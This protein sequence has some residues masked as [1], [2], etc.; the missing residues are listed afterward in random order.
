MKFHYVYLL[1]FHYPL[2]VDDQL[3][4]FHALTSGQS[5]LNLDEQVEGSRD[6]KSLLSTFESFPLASG[7]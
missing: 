7:I 1:H 6:H 5:L 3:D 4:C 2:L